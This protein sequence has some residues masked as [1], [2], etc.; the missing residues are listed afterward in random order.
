MFKAAA[1]ATLP[2]L[3][4]MAACDSGEAPVQNVTRITGPKENPYHK[5]LLALEPIQQRLAVRRAI[6]DEGGA[7]PSIK[8]SAYQQDYQGMAMWVGQCANKDWAVY[9][10][11]SG[12][13]Q[14]RPCPDAAALGLPACA[15]LP[16][17]GD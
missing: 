9:I 3:A 14:A 13:V 11:P 8:A 1:A 5:Q 12:I 17:A 2:I 7:C 6:Q 15:P 10:A 4:F 16:K